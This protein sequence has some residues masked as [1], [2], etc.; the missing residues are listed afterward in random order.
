MPAFSDPTPWFDDLPDTLTTH[1]S[2]D[3]ELIAA[4]LA[5]LDRVF[6]LLW[7]VHQKRIFRQLIDRVTVDPDHFVMRVTVDGLIDLI[8]ELLDERGLD[9]IR[10]RIIEAQKTN[11]T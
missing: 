8:F 4:R 7:P 1:P 10:A 9:V 11:E 3:R 5:K 2:F 6:D